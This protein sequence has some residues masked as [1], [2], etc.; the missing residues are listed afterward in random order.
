MIDAVLA[1]TARVFSMSDAVWARHANPWSGWTRMPIAPLLALAIWARAWIGVWCLVPIAVLVIW[2][3]VNP[4]A[5]PVPRVANSWMSRAVFGERVLL[6]AAAVPIPAH[7]ARAARLLSILPILGLP[8]L[9][10]GL[11]VY[12]VW[13]VVAGLVLAI[14]PKMWFLDR[15]VWLFD[16][17][18]PDHPDYAAWT[19][20]HA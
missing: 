8:P 16:D 2:T 7:H 10:Y 4:R 18:A 15:M 17:M 14:G 11:W 1:A 3:W 9:V 12:D 20:P 5:F 13:A 6:N 19:A